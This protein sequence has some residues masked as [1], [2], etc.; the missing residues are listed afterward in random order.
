MNGY[1]RLKIPKKI[2]QM[3]NNKTKISFQLIIWY[4]ITLLS[5]ATI[6]Y[7]IRFIQSLS[8]DGLSVS[9]FLLFV[10]LFELLCLISAINSLRNNLT[11]YTYIVLFY[12]I[13]QIFFFGIKGN[14]YTF[15]IGPAIAV[16]IKYVETFQWGHFI[17]LFSFEFL[18]KINT[19]SDR[20]Y[21][22]INLIPLAI[23]ILLLYL[24]KKLFHPNK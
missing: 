22:G 15:N 23:S 8:E 18:I 13:A 5:G 4:T 2:F 16:F 19:D 24:W 11:K 7:L 6:L 9:L 21:F 12:W 1:M 20:I 3:K 17:K 14:V 10:I